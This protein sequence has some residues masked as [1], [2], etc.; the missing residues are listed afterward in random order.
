[1]INK[2]SLGSFSASLSELTFWAVWADSIM[3]NLQ[4]FGID[5]RDIT[6]SFNKDAEVSIWIGILA[7]FSNFFHA[8]LMTISKN[9]VILLFEIIVDKFRRGAGFKHPLDMSYS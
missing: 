3:I 9:L 6:A 8:F 2:F 4:I 5:Q 1:M 7:V